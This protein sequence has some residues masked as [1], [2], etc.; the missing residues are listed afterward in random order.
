MTGSLL[1][2][3]CLRAMSCMWFIDVTVNIGMPGKTLYCR[4]AYYKTR[5]N[6]SPVSIPG[7]WCLPVLTS[8]LTINGEK[9]E[10]Y[11]EG[12]CL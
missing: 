8:L 1:S 10:H 2:L 5:P 7:A 12:F 9:I 4:I 11:F 6:I 3:D